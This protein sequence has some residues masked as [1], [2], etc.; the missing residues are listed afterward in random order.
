M[1]MA[2]GGALAWGLLSLGL[3]QAQSNEDPVLDLMVKKGLV[4]QAEADAARAEEKQNEE[5]SPASKIFLQTPSIQK[6]VFYGDGRLR[7]EN[8]DQKNHYTAFTLTDRERYRLRFG[9]DYYYSDN[10][11]GGFELESASAG[12]TAN[13]TLGGTFAKAS[14]NVGKIYLQY[15]PID[16]LTLVAGKFSNPWYT[17]TDIVYSFDLNPEGG[18]EL[19]NYT[20]PLGSGSGPVNNDPKEVKSGP[21]DDS[22]LTI[23]FN[24]VQYIYVNSNESTVVPGVNNNDVLIIGNQIPVTW[25]INKD[26]TLKV[27]PGFTF[28]TGGG[29]TNYDTGVPTNPSSLSGADNSTLFYGTANSAVDPVFYSPREADHLA[30]F[31]APG[32]FDFKLATV[33]VR[34]YW[35]F[36]YNTEGAARTQDVYLQHSDFVTPY[37]TG[38][39]AAAAARNRDLNDAVAW[40][41]GLQFGANK[42]KGDWSALGEF[43]Q[44]GLS[45]VDQNI[46]GT[47]YG[48]SYANQQGFKLAGAYNFTDF[49]TGT[50]TFYDTW[51]YKD[52]LYGALGGTGATPSATSAS[53]LNLVGEK[54][55]E[56]VQVDLGWKF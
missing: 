54:S 33:P 32:E 14:I 17:T 8:I 11:K 52:H 37:N 9:A 44:I 30:I 36:E 43:R 3:V 5:A 53:T 56:R 40:G 38:V 55:S 35:D 16:W 48:D 26:Y 1:K 34:A 31:S 25:K 23:G 7:F 39:T 13:Q 22:S 41:A 45:A 19:F 28:Y 27:A 47:D 24:A 29:N 51:S 12:D 50:V 2:I 20:F 49:L 10:F 18:A 21:A 42:K 15:Q 6:L 46:N 4:T